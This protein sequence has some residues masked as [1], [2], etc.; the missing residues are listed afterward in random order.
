MERENARIGLSNIPAEKVAASRSSSYPQTLTAPDAWRRRPFEKSCTDRLG[1][2]GHGGEHLLGSRG[3]LSSMNSGWLRTT[4]LYTYLDGQLASFWHPVSRQWMRPVFGPDAKRLGQAFKADATFP[5]SWICQAAANPE[6]DLVGEI[7]A[8]VLPEPVSGE[9]DLLRGALDI[10]C[11][12]EEDSLGK[13]ALAGLGV[14]VAVIGLVGWNRNRRAASPATRPRGRRE[15]PAHGRGNGGLT[16]T[17]IRTPV[18]D[19]TDEHVAAPSG[20][21]AVAPEFTATLRGAR[22]HFHAGLA[23]RKVAFT[24]TREARPSHR[25]VGVAAAR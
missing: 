10:A 7:I 3:T 18:S 15:H 4:P 12:F 16:P 19:T 6:V 11:G 25:A 21:T 14:A 1:L 24:E 5:T 13:V 22:R 20:T 8:L 9:I 2:L 17:P 23:H